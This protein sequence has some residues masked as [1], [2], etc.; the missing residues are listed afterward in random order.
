MFAFF[1]YSGKEQTVVIPPHVLMKTCRLCLRSCKHSLNTGF[2]G[3]IASSAET[4]VFFLILHVSLPSCDLAKR[5]RERFANF[6]LS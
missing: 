3:E 4:G 2:F 1:S 6:Q 5:V